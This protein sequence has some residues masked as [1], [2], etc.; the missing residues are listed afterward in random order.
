MKD[1]KSKFLSAS[2]RLVLSET[3]TVDFGQ[4]VFFEAR[5]MLCSTTAEAD[6][7]SN[8]QNLRCFPAFKALTTTA[9]KSYP[10]KAC[11]LQARSTPI[12][13]DITTRPQQRAPG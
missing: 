12:Q 3:A 7:P 8:S 1:H 6:F 11:S 4:G 10:H 2:Q 5:E 13:T 9:R